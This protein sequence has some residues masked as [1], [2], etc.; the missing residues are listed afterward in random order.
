MKEL[1]KSSQEVWNLDMCDCSLVR[2]N[3]LKCKIER[4]ED[5]WSEQ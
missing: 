3:V 5:F 1:G 4:Q 2:E